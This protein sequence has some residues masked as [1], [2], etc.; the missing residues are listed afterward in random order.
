M[1]EIKKTLKVHQNLLNLDKYA[2]KKWKVVHG[3]GG[4]RTGKA[5]QAATGG[6]NTLR[7]RANLALRK[8]MTLVHHNNEQP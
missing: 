8:N 1:D 3:G 6:N 5:S 2:K 4:P 7:Q